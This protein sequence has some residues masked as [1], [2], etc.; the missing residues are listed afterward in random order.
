MT[1]L[2]ISPK[3]RKRKLQKKN[4][5]IILLVVLTRATKIAVH[6]A[7]NAPPQY[8]PQNAAI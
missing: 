7:L 4:V 5:N 2:R 1:A 8:T 6:I 3:K